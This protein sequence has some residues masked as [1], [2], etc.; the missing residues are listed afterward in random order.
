MNFNYIIQPQLFQNLKNVI[1]TLV[2][3]YFEFISRTILPYNNAV[4]YYM[5][6]DLTH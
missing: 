3:K 6:G 4:F 5:N 2:I 1:F